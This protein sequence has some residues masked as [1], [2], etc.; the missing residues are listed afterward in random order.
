MHLVIALLG[1]LVFFIF[2]TLGVRNNPEQRKIFFLYLVID[3]WLGGVFLYLVGT[4][5]LH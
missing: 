2:L 5:V 3:L 4:A 1:A